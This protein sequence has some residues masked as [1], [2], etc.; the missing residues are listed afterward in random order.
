[1]AKSA[2][3]TELSLLVDEYDQV[4][5]ESLGMSD[6]EFHEIEEQLFDAIVDSGYRAVIKNGDI[7]LPDPN[8]F[9]GRSSSSIPPSRRIWT[10]PRSSTST[11]T[12][13]GGSALV[14]CEAGDACPKK[15][16]RRWPRKR[17][18]R[19]KTSKTG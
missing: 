16:T 19:R 17:S 11:K 3:E 4:A 7:Y 6:P 5:E 8:G 10:T 9:Q 13:Y 18:P 2:D 1:M 12:E 14:P 15:G